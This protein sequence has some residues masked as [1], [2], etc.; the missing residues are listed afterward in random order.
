VAGRYGFLHA[1]GDDPATD[2]DEGARPGDALRVIVDGREYPGKMAVWTG[3]LS[4]TRVDLALSS[5]PTAVSE[6]RPARFAFDGPQPNPFNPSVLLRFELATR[7]HTRMEVFDGLGR[8]VR[9]VISADLGPGRH[10]ATW[11]GVDENGRA[12][13][14]GLYVIRLSAPDGVITRRAVLAR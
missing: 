6:A 1:Y 13:A 12:V 11:D 8:H 10:E 7:G 9:T 2:P 5:A 3:S 4:V 14:S